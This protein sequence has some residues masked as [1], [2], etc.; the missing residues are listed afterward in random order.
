MGRIIETVKKSMAEE[1]IQFSIPEGHPNAI[2]YF[3][4]YN[5]LTYFV[6]F[7]EFEETEMLQMNVMAPTTVPPESRLEVAHF[8]TRINK[9]FKLGFLALDMDDGSLSFT[10]G[11]DLEGMSQSAKNVFN[12]IYIG[13]QA[14]ERHFPIIMS[15]CYGGKSAIEALKEF[16]ESRLGI[17][18]KL[19]V[20]PG[21][22]G[23]Q[24][25]ESAR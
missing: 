25:H 7:Q 20:N 3:L 22:S 9:R 23:R 2:T 12:M 13:L 17:E 11:Y 6:V 10:L 16:D 19:A 5:G 18:L 4:I 15:I 14:I 1:D 24:D 21:D 8:L